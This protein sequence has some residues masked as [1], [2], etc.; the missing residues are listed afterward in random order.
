MNIILGTA[1]F[2][3]DYGV[4]N[5]TGQVHLNEVKNILTL[6]REHG[7]SHFDTAQAYG[8]SESILGTTLRKDATIT[9]KVPPMDNGNHKIGDWIRA[10]VKKSISNLGRTFIDELLFHRVSDLLHGDRLEIASALNELKTEGI[11]K[12]TGVSIYDFDNLHYL[13]EHFDIDVIQAPFNL[14]DRRLVDEGWA[15]VIK[16]N[17]I[18][19]DVRSVFLQGLLLMSN[20][21]RNSYFNQWETLWVEFDSWRMKHPNFSQLDLCLQFVKQ[22]S[23]IDNVVIGVQSTSELQQV[24]SSF[25]SDKNVTMSSFKCSDINLLNPSRWNLI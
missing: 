23:Q 12:R 4:S 16:R 9:S 21:Q 3:L 11:I 19:L 7:L 24:L 25:H 15:D 17:N 6:C 8:D 10:S 20:E 1:Q 13:I 2:G 18:R 22:Y 5:Y 14:F